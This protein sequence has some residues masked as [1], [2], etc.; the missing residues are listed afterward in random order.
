MRNKKKAASNLSPVRVDA[1]PAEP[2][3]PGSGTVSRRDFLA[4]TAVTGI[5]LG[6]GS[7]ASAHAQEGPVSGSAA[8]PQSETISSLPTSEPFEMYEGTAAGAVLEQLR[9]AGVRMLFHTNTSGYTPFWEAVDRAGDVQVINVTH[10]GLAVAAAAGYAMASRTLGFFFGSNAGV[11]NS[12]SNLYCAWK[13]RVPLLVTYGGGRLSSQGKDGFESWDDQLRPTE[14]FTMWTA[15]LLTD[16][17]AEI[18]RRAMRFAYG[19]PSGP[20]TMVWG[21]ARSG[22]R[23][24]TRIDKIDLA[25]ARHRFRGEPDAIQQTARWLVEAEHPMFVIGPEVAEDGASKDLVALAEKL[26]IPVSD[27]D[28]DLYAIFPTDHPLFVGQMRTVRDAR[29]VDLLVSFGE[30]FRRRRPRPGTPV[31]QISHDPN[32]LGRLFPAALTIA[33]DVRTAVRDLSDAVDGLL[34]RDRMSRIRSSRL[35]EI[36]AQTAQLRK[37]VEV[38]LRARFDRSPVTWERVG[39]ELERA[40]DR[41]AV[42]VPEVGTQYYKL[43]RQLTLGGDNKLKFGRTIGSALGW[44][45]GAAL[46]VNLA[47]PERQVVALQGDGGFL[48]GQSETFWSIARYEVPMLIVIMNNRSYNETRAR[49]TNNGGLFFES[50]RDYNG[51]LGDPDVEYTKIAEAYGLRGEKVRTSAELAPALQRSLRGMRDG[52][53]VLLDIDVAPDGPVLRD[54]TWYQRYSVAD[55]QRRNRNA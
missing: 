12:M 53:A 1:T 23:V 25:S 27:T 5:A 4:A 6:A 55:I 51:Y 30:N 43:M 15:N 42:I 20:V 37:S 41:N 9:A 32:I 13:D 16:E 8:V 38:A 39:F 45:M 48:F 21:N 35:A 18:V 49:N 28:D 50:G 17:M 10:E 19:P 33:S 46:G 29:Q 54:S 31:V 36:S 26:S 2:S 7:A 24:R 52:K 14:P 40:L 44:G 11:P 3:S 34:T 22:E 47:L